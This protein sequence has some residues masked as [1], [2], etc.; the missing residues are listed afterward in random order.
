MKKIALSLLITTFISATS[1]AA[2]PVAAA[3]ATDA[4]VAAQAQEVLAV[5]NATTAPA[6]AG[7]NAAV[8]MTFENKGT[9]A[10]KIK[11]V[12]VDAKIA[13]NAK[14]HTSTAEKGMTPLDGI[15]V[16]AGG[17]VELVQGGDHLMLNVLKNPLKAG[18]KF[19]AVLNLEGE[20]T[21]DV[22]VT[23]K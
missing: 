4:T 15:T 6:Q 5:T 10:V 3:P 9:E 18:D 8:Y 12:S 17:K 21:Q 1:F 13:A 11:S 19:H 20:K 23:V 2:E 22:E 16:P 7:Q 14:L